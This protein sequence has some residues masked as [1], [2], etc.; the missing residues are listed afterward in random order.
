MIAALRLADRI[1]AALCKGG[2]IA[3]LL[4]LFVL[5]GAAIILRLVPLF[6]IQGYDEIVELLFIWLVMLTTLALWRE[7]SLYRVVLF[8]DLLPV[9]ARRWLEVGLH[10]VMFGFALVLVVYGREFMEMS[11]ETT[12]FLR[13]D[14]GWWYAAIPLT[15]ALMAVYSLVWIWRAVRRGE[16]LESAATLV[17]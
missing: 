3:C 17:G 9:A 16:T 1:V 8:E 12:P 11:G 10:V 2:A 4:G 14:K 6:T 15:A 7:G 5:L 13:L